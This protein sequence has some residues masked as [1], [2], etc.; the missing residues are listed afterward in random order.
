[1]S[2]PDLSGVTD[3][4]FPA[5]QRGFSDSLDGSITAGSTSLLLHSVSGYT[6]GDSVFLWI[7]PNNSN[8]ELVFGIVNTGTI[9]LTSLVRGVIGVA[10]AHSSGATVA[11]YVSSADHMSLR[12]G[13][14]VE[15]NQDGTHGNITAD[16]I[17]TDSLTVA[18]VNI[19]NTVY[20]VG[21]IY[22][23]ATS[24]TNPSTLLGFGTWVAFGTG[25]VLVSKAASGT[26]ATAGATGGEETH[27][28]TTAE[29]ASHSHGVNDSGHTHSMPQ[30]MAYTDASDRLTYSGGNRQAYGH[31]AASVTNSSS[32]GISI[33]NSGSGSAHN[34]LQPYIV[35]YMW[36]RTA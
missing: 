25:R 19:L 8:A 13:L 26:F 31:G 32:T 1:M 34:N 29:L 22:T 11:Q 7:D 2:A 18:G 14:L 35:V 33:Q 24:S 21:S 28:L 12:K 17:T 3:N 36:Q 5:V 23:N 10:S 20:P 15:H 16:S 6:N 4:Y 27:T 30:D 9:A